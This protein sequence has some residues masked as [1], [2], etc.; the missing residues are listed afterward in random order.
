MINVQQI[1]EM[2]MS[3]YSEIEARHNRCEH[4]PQND[5]GISVSAWTG[6][7]T[8]HND[9]GQLLEMH[10]E[11]LREFGKS[12]QFQHKTE[13][14]LF[15]RIKKLE[16]KVALTPTV[17]WEQNANLPERFSPTPPMPPVKPP[18]QNIVDEYGFWSEEYVREAAEA[19]VKSL[20]L[21]E[22]NDTEDD[23]WLDAFK[24]PS[25]DVDDFSELN[26][27]IEVNLNHTVQVK[28]T[29]VGLKELAKRHHELWNTGRFPKEFK[30]FIPPSTDKDGWTHYQL[31][32][33]MEDFGE[34]IHIGCLVPFE[35][36]IR[37]KK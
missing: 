18:K 25:S 14:E 5:D 31:W 15:E 4:A 13:H 12:C 33:L 29:E 16:A 21:S 9:R 20:N 17:D 37:I 34:I 32:S 35:T 11:L 36:T 26:D 2:V 30:K 6:Y 22:E 23:A 8:A 24:M 10:K 1:M 19:W 28:L 7:V 27:F 3:E